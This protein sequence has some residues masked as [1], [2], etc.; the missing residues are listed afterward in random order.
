[1]KSP[2]WRSRCCLSSSAALP[3]DGAFEHDFS[4][5]RFV[6]RSNGST[7]TQELT[8]AD[9]SVEQI[10]AFVIGSGNHAFGFLT[11]VG[12]HIFQ[13]PI[14]YYTTRRL[15]DVAPG[16]ETDPHPDFSRPVTPECLFCHSGK[17]ASHFRFVEPISTRSVCGVW[18]HL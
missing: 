13:S 5:T 17:R 4:Q 11:Q 8:R 16:Y 12:D 18:H 9:E 7:M 15:W 3:P 10:T 6:I 14:S 1:M 2:V